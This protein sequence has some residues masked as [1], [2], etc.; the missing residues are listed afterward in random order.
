ML[1]SDGAGSLQH[2]TR[3]PL[4]V[5]GEEKLMELNTEKCKFASKFR[6]L[7]NLYGKSTWNEL[8]NHRV[9]E[10]RPDCESFKVWELALCARQAE[11]AAF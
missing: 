10:L 8:K 2:P 7:Q 6:V 3:M 11:P 1:R 5:S 4:L 9:L